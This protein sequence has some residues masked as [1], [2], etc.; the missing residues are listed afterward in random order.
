M[1]KIL[2][3][4]GIVICGVLLFP[5]MLIYKLFSAFINC[6]IDWFCLMNEL[7]LADKIVFNDNEDN[8]ED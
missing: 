4:L 3:S 1:L 2:K 7:C 8:T 6:L 5:F